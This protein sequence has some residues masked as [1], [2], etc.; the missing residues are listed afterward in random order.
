MLENLGNIPLH[1]P[2]H[3]KMLNFS[4]FDAVWYVFVTVSTIGYELN[5]HATI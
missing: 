1:P 4:F 5:L 2:S 3:D